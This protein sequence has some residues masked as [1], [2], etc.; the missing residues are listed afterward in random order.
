MTEDLSMFQGIDTMTPEHIAPAA[1]FLGSDLC[2][3]RTGHVLAVAGARVYVYKVV[4][5]EGKFT[6]GR[7]WTADEIADNWDAIA[8]VGKGV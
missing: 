4:E 7:P 6:E 2:G 8:R 1:L 3:D 5:S